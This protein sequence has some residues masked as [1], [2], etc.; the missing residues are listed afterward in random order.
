MY[1]HW[2]SFVSL[3]I[4]LSAAG[5]REEKIQSYRVPKETSSDPSPTASPHGPSESAPASSERK[6]PWVVPQG[7]VDKASNSGMRVA[8]YGVSTPDGRSA[9]ISIIAL[10]G[11]GGGALTNVNR[12]RDQIGL[13]PVN[14]EEL[15]QS[16]RVVTIG[17]REA[18]LY[19][20]NGDR[21]ISG[22]PHTN[23]T[24]AAVMPSGDVTVFF[25]MTGERAVVT[26][27]RAKFMEWLKSVNTG[28][29]GSGHSASE[30]EPASGTSPT[31]SN[32]AASPS[33]STTV[34]AGLPQWKAPAHWQPAGERPMRLASFNVPG[35]AGAAPADLSISTL[36]GS[37]GGM[38]ANVNRWR[39]QLGLAAWTDNDLGRQSTVIDLDG[40]R[41]TVVDLTGDKS[42]Q[43][44]V[45]KTRILAAI[46]PR[47][48]QTWFYK[49]TG[50]G[51][52]VAR[53]KENFLGFLKSIKHPAN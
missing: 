30:P 32:R 49:L 10:E 8:S 22:S 23:N 35:D 27:N 31:T 9:D 6:T 18:V 5:C 51:A 25:K 2:P 19:E 21:A 11:S 20:L 41:A 47:G 15:S 34:A 44:E 40:N 3:A 50:E 4:A 26:E 38:L 36:S 24:L 13:T 39:G 14:Q 48:E 28:G 52:V 42:P 45:R 12:W 53:E 46:M 1:R 43:G 33:S 17:Q 37:G 29:G 16:S 7:W